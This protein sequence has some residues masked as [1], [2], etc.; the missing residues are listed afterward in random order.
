MKKILATLIVFITL[1]TTI[2]SW[3]L[4]KN[5]YASVICYIQSEAPSYWNQKVCIYN[6]AGREVKILIDDREMCP[7]RIQR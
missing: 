5:S 3:P 1:V 6:C 4:I 2:L 7:M